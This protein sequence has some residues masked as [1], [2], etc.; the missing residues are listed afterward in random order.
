VAD[1]HEHGNEPSGYV[2]YYKPFERR[3]NCWLLGS[4]ELARD[5]RQLHES[6]KEESFAL[7]YGMQSS[8]RLLDIRSNDRSTCETF[9][10]FDVSQ[11]TGT[12]RR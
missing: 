1:S 11:T 6:R 7:L 5:Y 8:R 2:S 3:R 10:D 4:I 9:A 12:D